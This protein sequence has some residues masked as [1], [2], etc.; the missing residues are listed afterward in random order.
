MSKIPS[1][2]ISIAKNEKFQFTIIFLVVG[3]LTWLMNKPEPQP[4]TVESEM[5]AIDKLLSDGQ[6]A[7]PIELS[8]ADSM[9]ALVDRVALVNLYSLHPQTLKA[10]Q[11]VASR[12]RLARSPR[13]S[14]RFFVILTEKD[15]QKLIEKE[16]PFYATIQS[17]HSRKPTQFVESTIDNRSNNSIQIVSEL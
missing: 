10:N 5:F 13:D 2:I 3:I 9:D 11:K 1:N 17:R 15:H 8:N 16:G 12:V 4:P 7:A 14:S 6:M